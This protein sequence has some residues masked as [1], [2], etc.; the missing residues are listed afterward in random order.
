MRSA[1]C[2]G[3]YISNWLESKTGAKQGCLLSAIKFILFIDD[4]ITFLPAGVNIVN[5]QI[6]ALLY[7]CRYVDDTYNHFGQITWKSA[8]DD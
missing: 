2:D 3:E 1:V 8:V 4:I 6:K 7:V 5:T